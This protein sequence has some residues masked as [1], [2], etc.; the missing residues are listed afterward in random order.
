[1]AELTAPQIKAILTLKL[2]KA[3]LRPSAAEI[4]SREVMMMRGSDL[5]SVRAAFG[6]RAPLIL[7]SLTPS[8]LEPF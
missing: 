2:Q 5:T 4:K 1:M 6:V 8:A 7:F 3:G